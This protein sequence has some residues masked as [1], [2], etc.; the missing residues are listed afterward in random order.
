MHLSVILS[1]S[2]AVRVII[3]KDYLWQ[4][5]GIFFNSSIQAIDQKDNNFKLWPVNNIYIF[6][7]LSKISGY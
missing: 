6:E 3:M 1:I 2:A 7:K 5:E 4:T